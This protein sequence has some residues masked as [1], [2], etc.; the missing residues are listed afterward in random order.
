VKRSRLAAAVIG[1]ALVGYS[2]A[3]VVGATKTDSRFIWPKNSQFNCSG[4]LI[5]D[6]GTYQLKPDEGMLAWGD[7]EIEG[8]DKGR[9]LDACT[10]GD[11]CEIKGVIRGHG[12]FGW[13]KITSVRSLKQKKS[14]GGYTELPKSKKSCV[15]ADPT[16]TPLNVR[17]RPNGP[18]LGAL[19]NDSEVFIT[20][21]TEVGGRKWAKVVPLGEGK[22]GWVFRDYLTC[23]ATPA[24]ADDKLPARLVGNW[25]APLGAADE[26]PYEHVSDCRGQRFT[27][28]Q[29]SMDSQDGTDGPNA[30]CKLLQVIAVKQDDYIVKYRCD[31]EGFLGTSIYRF[32]L[33]GSRLTITDIGSNYPTVPR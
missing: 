23:Q 13:V 30:K 29:D 8:K 22:T 25:C 18:I 33:K 26:V 27:I 7:A 12:A 20:D 6:E 24:I 9:V 31:M 3:A 4:I 10:V 16:G 14:G 5:Q 1:L 17:N 28:R 15:V 11:R 19:S 21:M 32:S 2:T